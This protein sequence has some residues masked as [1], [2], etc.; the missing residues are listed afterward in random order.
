MLTSEAFLFFFVLCWHKSNASSQP[1]IYCPARF[2]KVCPMKD[3]SSFFEQVACV[4]R[5]Y[6][7]KKLSDFDEKCTKLAIGMYQTHN[8]D[9]SEN[10][11][12]VVDKFNKPSECSSIASA[13]MWAG[14]ITLL[15]PS[16]V[17]FTLVSQCSKD[18]LWMI[19]EICK[20]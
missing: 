2:E 6:E 15:P 4:V 17:D 1:S 16:D 7:M 3:H 19:G 10:I 5:L 9:T 11:N 18:R 13:N 20:V 14:N 12:T 8:L